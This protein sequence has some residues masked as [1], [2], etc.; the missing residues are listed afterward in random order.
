MRYAPLTTYGDA[1]SLVRRVV[2]YDHLAAIWEPEKR[3]LVLVDTQEQA[4]RVQDLRQLGVDV[5]AASSAQLAADDVVRC[6]IERRRAVVLYRAADVHHALQLTNRCNSYCLMCSQPPTPQADSWLVAQAL[7]VIRHIAESPRALGLTGGEP[8]LLGADL[9]RIVTAIRALHPFTRAEI[10]TNARLLGR[11]ELRDEVLPVIPANGVAWL[12]PLYGHA[13]FLHDFVVQAPGAFDQT[14]AGLLNLRQHG[15]A[16]QLRV[17]LIKPVLEYLPDLCQFIARNLPF[18]HEVALMACEPIGFALGNEEHC[19]VDLSEWE[20]SLSAA[21]QVLER[22]K[23]PFMFM[24]TPL[25]ALPKKLRAYAIQSI[26]DWKN[27]YAK[28]CGDCAARA[29]CCG[30]FTWHEAH[31]APA[32]LRPI[33]E[34]DAIP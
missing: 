13:D 3:F 25:C 24:N 5:I 32:P 8:T 20:V 17:V 4:A 11:P 31:W 29:Q 16:I 27:E 26:S 34:E 19:R 7:E 10:L 23:V 21:A 14:I 6:E 1:D 15:H 33:Y 12:V 28:E 18:V 9:A 2:G 22:S 30:L